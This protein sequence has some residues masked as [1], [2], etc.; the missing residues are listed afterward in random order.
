LLGNGVHIQAAQEVGLRDLDPWRLVLCRIAKQSGI[1]D[2]A[3]LPRSGPLLWDALVK[4][5]SAAQGLHLS[6]THRKLRESLV[7]HLGSIERKRN[8]LPLF[9][10]ILDLCFE[11]ILS[12]NIDRTLALHSTREIFVSEESWHRDPTFYRH[13]FIP[14][15]EGVAT[16][17][18]Y[19]QGDTRDASVI[20]LGT[21]EYPAQLMSLED[22]RSPMINDWVEYRV[23]RWSYPEAKPQTKLKTPARFYEQCRKNPETWY[24]LAFVAPLVIIGASL[25]LEDWPIWWLLHQ[26]ARN[27]TQFRTNQTPPTF[28][29]SAKGEAHPHLSG[30]PSEMEV[31]VFPSHDALWKFVLR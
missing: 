19:P 25:A 7:H 26:R 23:A 4:H 31:V 16:R 9:G 3:R 6:Q 12:L 24:R 1:R 20:R 17:I 5:A 14:H 22:W 21:V 28:F 15:V 8:A 30:R 29:L 2:F 27:L 18:W 11:N 10:R 13:S